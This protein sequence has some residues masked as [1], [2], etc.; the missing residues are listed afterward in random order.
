[1]SS[2]PTPPILHIDHLHFAYPGDPP[3]ATDWS[4]GIGA[5]VTLLHGDTGSG[6]STLLRVLAGALPATGGRLRL[7]GAAL[8]GARFLACREGMSRRCAPGALR[9]TRLAHFSTLSDA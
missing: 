2:A 5:G 6:K 7:A 8:P 3:I 9:R 4:A 1:M